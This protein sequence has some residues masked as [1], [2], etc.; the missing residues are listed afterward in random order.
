MGRMSGYSLTV[1]YMADVLWQV[2]WR[3]EELASSRREVEHV[4]LDEF[5]VRIVSL[6]IQTALR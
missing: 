3:L 4:G 1:L 5:L 6:T 2:N